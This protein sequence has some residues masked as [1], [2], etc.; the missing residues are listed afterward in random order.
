MEGRSEKLGSPGLSQGNVFVVSEC[1]QGTEDTIGEEAVPMHGHHVP[2]SPCLTPNSRT[3][4]LSCK[5]HG[6]S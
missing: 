1:G 5:C 4:N 3:R 2:G 6:Q